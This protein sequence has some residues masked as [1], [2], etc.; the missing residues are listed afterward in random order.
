M[1]EQV[2]RIGTVKVDGSSTKTGIP[3]HP[4][5]LPSCDDLRS[6][7]DDETVWLWD[8]IMRKN[9]GVF[10]GSKVLDLGCANGYFSF[11]ISKYADRVTAIDYDSEVIALNQML[12][13]YHHIPNVDFRCEDITP[14]FAKRLD[15]YDVAFCLNVHHWWHKR[16]GGSGAREILHWLSRHVRKMFFMTASTNSIAKYV[17]KEMGRS[18]SIQSYLNQCG[19]KAKLLGNDRK[20]KRYLFDCI[21]KGKK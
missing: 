2:K 3:Y 6:T 1:R 18:K 5:P 7:T 10:R 17:V 9:M 21:T 19:W 11:R 14:D 20:R 12:S 15:D 4:I 8:T 16:H 13:D